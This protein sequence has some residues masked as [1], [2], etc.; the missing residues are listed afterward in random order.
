MTVE[1][2]APIHNA[3]IRRLPCF[4]SMI[5]DDKRLATAAFVTQLQSTPVD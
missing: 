5:A 3:S 2:D 4:R 1:R